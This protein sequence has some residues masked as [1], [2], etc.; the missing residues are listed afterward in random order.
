M[1]SVRN[2]SGRF[3]LLLPPVN[4]YIIK[5]HPHTCPIVF[6]EVMVSYPKHS[7]DPNYGHTKFSPS[8]WG[9]EQRQGADGNGE[10][11]CAFVS[12]CGMLFG[13][14]KECAERDQEENVFGKGS[15]KNVFAF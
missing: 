9:K 13:P 10:G 11:M 5:N 12:K 3:A 14:R 15:R 8:G 6:Y 4:S 2:F 1:I 7:P